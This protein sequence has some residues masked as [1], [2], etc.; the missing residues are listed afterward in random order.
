MTILDMNSV[1]ADE[2]RLLASFSVRL[3]EIADETGAPPIAALEVLRLP[4]LALDG[5]GHVVGVNAAARAMFDAELEVKDRCLFVRDPDA[6]ALLSAAIRR[7]RTQARLSAKFVVR[8][9][10]RVPV[11]VR[12]WPLPRRPRP[13][14]QSSG[15]H[16]IV[17][18]M[19]VLDAPRHCYLNF[20]ES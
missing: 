13:R 9:T 2:E 17:T 7:L 19:P 15:V 14:S 12:I 10:N 1:N 5:R 8:R 18:A 3:I 6:R 4:A 16:A 20:S 11:A